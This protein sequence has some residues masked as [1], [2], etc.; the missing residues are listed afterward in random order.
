MFIRAFRSVSRRFYFTGNL[1]VIDVAANAKPKSRFT[2]HLSAISPI[3]YLEVEH[4]HVHVDYNILNVVVAMPNDYSVANIDHF[5]QAA[6]REWDLHY[7]CLIDAKSEHIYLRVKGQSN[8]YIDQLMDDPWIGV[9]K[10][11]H[12]IDQLSSDRLEPS[13]R[14]I[15]IKNRL[16]DKI[17]D[18][19]DVSYLLLLLYT[20]LPINKY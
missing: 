10:L 3:H 16:I 19:Y 11:I 8:K 5:T 20:G 1:P 6:I 7:I 17:I 9:G 13:P 4:T 12:L 15:E 2:E 14:L 18:R